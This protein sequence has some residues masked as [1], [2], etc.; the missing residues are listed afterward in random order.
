M[1]S[2]VINNAFWIIGCRI[3]Q[4]VLALL[5]NMMTARYLGPANYGLINYAAALVTFFTPIMRLGLD[6]VLVQEIITDIE[7]E[8]EKLG[9]AIVLNLLSGCACIASI[10][11]FVSVANPF[12]K[13]TLIVCFLYSS[14]L[15]F[16]AFDIIQ[17]WFQAK[18]I[19]KY[20][21]IAMLLSYIV[22]TCYQI[23]ILAMS[24]GV[25]WFAVSKSIEFLLIDIILY[26]LYKKK[27]KNK[28]V[29]SGNVA[30]EMF[31]K[32][33]YYIISNMMVVVFAQTDRI[34]LKTMMGDEAT[35]YY[36]AAVSC[37][38]MTSFVFAA[39]VDS[40][41]PSVLESYGANRE[42]F[43]RKMKN[44]Y[45]VVIYAALIQSIVITLL[46]PFII[47]LIYGDGYVMAT[48]VLKIVVWY[49]TFSYIGTVRN[50]WILANNKQKLLVRVNVSGALAN[51]CLNFLMIPRF[52]MEGA[53]IASLL[54][55][56][57]TNVLTGFWFAD[58][59]ENNFLLFRSLNPIYGVE[60][61]KK[62]TF[63]N[64]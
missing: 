19:S 50:V 18:L 5:V 49:T 56:F 2:R 40:A 44:L 11:M 10:M 21:S 46:S 23:Y 25:Y 35:G 7:K 27:G 24:K 22:M 15:I 61:I 3:V 13:D 58:L 16:N 45:C 20:T 55:Q 29:F 48:N 41:R 39:I 32:S 64:K 34:M 14:I 42:S 1:K 53:A 63:K 4:A 51:V 60:V 54:T 9:T 59:K 8:G 17:Y 6:G 38:T 26:L 52:G 47:N 30:K 28:L 33:K 31:S 37:A 57:F 62:I 12:E 43:E 36:S